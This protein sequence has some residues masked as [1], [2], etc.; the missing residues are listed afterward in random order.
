MEERVFRDD[1]A[2]RALDALDASIGARNLRTVGLDDDITFC[3]RES[4]IDVIPR[5]SATEG[6]V[7]VLEHVSEQLPAGHAGADAPAST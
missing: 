4:M 1:A 5:V 6:D 7:A 2:H 3:A